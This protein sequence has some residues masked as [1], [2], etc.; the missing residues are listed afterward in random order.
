[1]RR[2]GLTLAG[3][4]TSR[5]PTI[6]IS[7]TA[8]GEVS[9]GRAATR[10]GARPGDLIYVSGRLGAAQLGLELILSGLHRKRRSEPLLRRPLYPDFHPD[11]KSVVEGRGGDTAGG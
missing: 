10:S 8:V 11:R 5:H 9:K 1:A 2:L 6:A 7:I 4:D 3:G